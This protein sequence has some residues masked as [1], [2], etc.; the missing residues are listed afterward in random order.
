MDSFYLI[1]WREMNFNIPRRECAHLNAVL[2]N[3][4]KLLDY[5]QYV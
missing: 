1:F 4:D 5:T 2:K 3:A